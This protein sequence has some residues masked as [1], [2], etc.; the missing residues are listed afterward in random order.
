MSRWRNR[1]ALPL[2]DNPAEPSHLREDC[3]KAFSNETERFQKFNSK[4][5]QTYWK[6]TCSVLKT[7]GTCDPKK[8]KCS[9]DILVNLVLHHNSHFH[10]RMPQYIEICMEM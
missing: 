3:D 6:Y 2:A 4:F 8:M 1:P 9:S 5:N 10:C 7:R